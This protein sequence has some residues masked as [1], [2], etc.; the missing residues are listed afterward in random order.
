MFRCRCAL[1]DGIT[2]ENVLPKRKY[3][4]IDLTK[5]VCSF[6]IVA[7]HSDLFYDRSPVLYSVIC[8]GFAR[9]A[10]PFFFTASAFFFFQRKPTTEGTKKYC[11][12]LLKLYLCWFIVYLPKTIFDRI[13]SSEFPFPETMFRFVRAFFVSSTFSGSWFL[14]SCI[15][16][17]ILF[18]GL[19]R[20]PERFRRILT[21]AL[22]AAVY[23]VCV[24][25]SGYGALIERLGLTGVYKTYTLLFANP[26]NNLFVGIP[27]FA[28]GRCFAYA[29][30]QR[31]R[32]LW[33]TGAIV[34]LLLLIAEVLLTKQCGL[35]K[36]TD[37][38]LMLFPCICFVFPLI[39][40]SMIQLKYAQLMRNTSTIVFF[41]HFGW[42]FLV[43]VLEWAAKIDVP[44][45]LKFL[46]AITGS[47]FTTFIILKLQRLKSFSW[48]RYFY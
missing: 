24:F 31:T 11:V 3:D 23:F 38:Y 41:S 16:C 33:I 17:A 34:S 2:M 44:F 30:R 14:A 7:L 12:R 26:Y 46:A 6:L 20:L 40:E 21:V 35:T 5:L 37:C 13:I 28:L 19:E 27:Y 39:K 8:S 43:E 15:F 22:S 18:T 1:F 9:L 32:P 10:V 36:A 25:T 45:S 48:F 29:E 47:L 4:A 42:L